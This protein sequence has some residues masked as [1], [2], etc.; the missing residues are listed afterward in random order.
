MKKTNKKKLIERMEKWINK[1][2]FEYREDS[3]VPDS[4]N[5]AIG[6]NDILKKLN[7]LKHE[8]KKLG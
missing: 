1:N 7:T 8:K 2:C 5:W 4:N 6:K 3:L